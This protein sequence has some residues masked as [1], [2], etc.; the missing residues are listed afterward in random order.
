MMRALIRLPLLLIPLLLA[1]PATSADPRVHTVS[2]ANMRFG[3]VPADVKLGDIIVWV[4]N[5]IVP[6][7]A[8]AR[9]GAFDVDLAPRQS[10]R[11]NVTRPGSFAFYCRYHP[12]MRGS[13]N[14]AR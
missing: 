14:V 4:N 8:T 11:M 12:A 7:T 10:R 13:L 9:N 2:M 1:S 3:A 5:D 6:H